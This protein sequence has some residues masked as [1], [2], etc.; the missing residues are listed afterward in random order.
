[1]FLFL[2]PDLLPSLEAPEKITHVLY[3][4]PLKLTIA[5]SSFRIEEC[6]FYSISASA[7]VLT[8]TTAT[9]TV[10]NTGFLQCGGWALEITTPIVDLIRCC[11]DRCSGATALTSNGNINAQNILLIGSGDPS[12]GLS[13]VS[14]LAK[15][16]NQYCNFTSNKGTAASL[17]SASA[18][19]ETYIQYLTAVENSAKVLFHEGAGG[20]RHY[21]E[22]AK[23]IRTDGSALI[24]T[25]LASMSQLSVA[26]SGFFDDR[27]K[28]YVEERSST[29][30]LNNCFFSETEAAAK[31]KAGKAIINTESGH[32]KAQEK[33]LQIGTADSG[34]CWDMV[35]QARGGSG[36]TT[37]A[38][39]VLGVAVVVAIAVVVFRFYRSGRTDTAPLMYV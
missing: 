35:P 2:L 24:S 3:D 32:F 8:S 11:F 20:S 4:H 38:V 28:V 21:I 23:F 33:D 37:A 36:W 34:K 17:F 19:V 26:Q 5:D 9:I 7:A 25:A 22:Q 31:A 16:T 15:F 27:C 30:E 13:K 6:G 18:G 29:V 12:F 10:T 1:L 39:V 14:S